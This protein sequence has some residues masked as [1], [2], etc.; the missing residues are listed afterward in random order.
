MLSIKNYKINR[1]RRRTLALMITANG[2]LVARAPTKMPLHYIENF[3]LQKQ[4]W[5]NNKLELVRARI[6][7]SPQ[8][9][10]I[11]G[12]N[13]LYL[14]KEYKLV[15][16]EYKKIILDENGFLFFPQ[17]YL[18]KAKIYLQFW[19]KKVASEK[20]A[21]RVRYFA[22]IMCLRYG[23]IKITSAKKR[24]GSCSAK[25]NLNFTWRLIVA[26]LWILDYVVVHELAHIIVKNHSRKYWN[27][28]VKIFPQ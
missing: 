21:E 3:I 12:E 25:N 20:I 26:P 19:Y 4:S 2:E 8:K 6:K 27:E 22:D 15:I 23:A 13:F 14:G 16:G 28:V 9:Q 11:D 24:Y 5:I 1:S 10:F 18:P 17:K 7:N